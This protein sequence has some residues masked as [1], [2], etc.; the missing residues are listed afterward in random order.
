MID[1]Q[2]SSAILRKTISEPHMG[3]E[4]TT[5]LVVIMLQVQSLSVAQKLFF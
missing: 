3:I 5:S 4:P 1:E 2:L